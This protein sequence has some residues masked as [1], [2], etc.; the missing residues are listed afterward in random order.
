MDASPAPFRLAW[1]LFRPPSKAFLLSRPRRHAGSD[2]LAKPD[3]LAHHCTLWYGG[4]CGPFS[5]FAEAFP[6]RR[7]FSARP[8]GVASDERVE[9][10]AVEVAGLRHQF[11]SDRVLHV[12]LS[13]APGIKAEDSVRLLANA[14]HFTAVDWP[15]LTG[16]VEYVPYPPTAT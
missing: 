3:R 12:T 8:V 1:L 7:E 6:A 9:A 16:V 10:L 11:G 15:S 5:E 14:P 13:L 2:H 4:E